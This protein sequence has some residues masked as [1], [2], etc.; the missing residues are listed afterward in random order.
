VTRRC[1]RFLA[2]LLARLVSRR[3]PPSARH[4][5]SGGR[6]RAGT[7]WLLLGV[8]ACV[9]MLAATPASAQSGGIPW[10]YYFGG[11]AG[12][13]TFTPPMFGDHLS[14]RLTTSGGGFNFQGSGFQGGFQG[15]FQTAFQSGFQGGFQTAFQSGFQGGGFGAIPITRGAAKIA[16]NESPAPQDRVYVHYNFYSDVD[17]LTDVHRETIGLEKALLGGRASLGLRLPFFE[18]TDDWDVGDLSIVLKYAPINGASQVLSTGLVITVPTGGVVTSFVVKGDHI[19]DV[20]PVQL[21]PFVGYLWRKD[22]FYIQGFASIMVPTD[23]DDATVGFLD[24]GLGYWVFR[25]G[26]VLTGIVPTLEVHANLPVN[27]RAEAD[28][29]RF[30]DTIDLTGGVHFMFKERVRL[31]VAAVVPLNSPRRF[32]FEVVA[33]L[34]YYF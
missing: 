24:L 21:Q 33:N 22:D 1:R 11:N 34:E 28:V 27:H 7:W 26:G 13:T 12:P 23:S 17:S 32:D 19:E 8:A 15:G 29:P 9:A 10:S 2:S 3:R 6:G 16:E 20:H 31:G 14:L 30:R 5:F 18:T 25:G 4:H